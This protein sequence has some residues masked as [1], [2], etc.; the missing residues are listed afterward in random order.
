[1]PAPHSAATSPHALPPGL[2]A[3]TRSGSGQPLGSRSLGALGRTESNTAA[4]L[5]ALDLASRRPASLAPSIAARPGAI[6]AVRQA[7]PGEYD[8]AAQAR[9]WGGSTCSAASLTAV[10]RSRGIPVRIADVMRAMPG[11]ITPE[12]G[13]VS[14]PALV[15]A[16]ERYGV[17]ARDDVSG[18]DALQRATASGQPVLVDIRNSRFPQGHWIVVTSADANGLQVADSSGYDLKTMSRADFVASWSGRGI[19]VGA[20]QTS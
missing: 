6:R 10:L 9:T 12:L 3:A 7:D 1:M 18:Y 2:I 14:R 4:F 15:A 17:A 11:A 8:S 19:R 13:L 16:A 5:R 20:G